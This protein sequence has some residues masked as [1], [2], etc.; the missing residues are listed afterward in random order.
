CPL[1]YLRI[2]A[3]PMNRFL[4]GYEHREIVRNYVALVAILITFATGGASIAQNTVS[5]RISEA[6]TLAA[7]AANEGQYELARGIAAG[8]LQR[9]PQDFAALMA[10]TAA[11]IGL[12]NW[13]AAVAAGRRAFRATSV[14]IQRVSAARLVASAHFRARQHTRAEWWLRR[15]LNLAPDQ[16][17]QSALRQDFAK[18]RQSNPLAV[19]LSFSTAPNNNVNN[20]SSSDT[21]NIFGLPFVLSP[22]ARALSGI[23]VSAGV[24]LKYRLA[25]GQDRATDI[26]LKLFGRTFKLSNAA[27]A[28]APDV[29]GSD[30]SFAVAEAFLMQTRRFANTSGPTTFIL[31]LGKNWF[32]TAPYSRY[33]RLTA[34]QTLQLTKA[35]GLIVSGGYERQISISSGGTPS[36]IFTLG[37]TVNHR[38]QNRDALSLSLR[39]QETTSPDADL[40]NTSV[41][42]GARYGFGTLVL[43]TS[44][45]LSMALEKRDYDVSVFDLSGRHDLTLSAGAAVAFPGISYFG[46]SPSL[47]VEASRTQS[48]VNIFDRESVAVRIG[49]QSN[50]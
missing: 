15:A 26:G 17:A 5:L 32:G 6:R 49:I 31:T 20:G 7:R 10:L 1:L 25:Q 38:L 50:F 18:V 41:K 45:S 11:E 39:L 42:A 43:G 29:S 48:N 40:E 23:E 46:F 16:A 47:S 4:A 35:T 28:A 36:N 9:D 14:N 21:I 44:V 12:G 34:A 24:D 8:L 27:Q 33:G 37:T 19:R 13:D 30:F 22:D 3:L 2:M